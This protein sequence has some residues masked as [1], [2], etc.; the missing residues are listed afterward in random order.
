MGVLKRKRGLKFF[1]NQEELA[2]CF[3]VVRVRALLASSAEFM[4]LE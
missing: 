1:G 3:D 4:L 2:R